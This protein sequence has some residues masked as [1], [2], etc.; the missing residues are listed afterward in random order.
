MQR[1]LLLAGAVCID[2]ESFAQA[3]SQM[4]KPR[5]KMGILSD[6]HIKTADDLPVLEKA[7]VFFRN[8]DVD[9]IVIAGDMADDGIARQL[10]M[11]G[12]TWYKVFPKDRAN[13]HKV[14]KIFV[15][16]NHDIEGTTY[17]S[18]KKRYSEE[19]GKQLIAD[20]S[21]A[22]HKDAAWKQAFKES[23]QPICLKEIKGFPF[24]ASQ[25]DNAHNT[26]G[27]AEFLQKNSRKLQGK[28]PFFYIQ[29]VHPKDTC[30]SPWVWGHDDGSATKILSQYPNCIC[31]SGHSHTT[32]TDERT[33]WQGAFTS[34]GTASLSY[35]ITFGGRENTSPAKYANIAPQMPKLSCQDGKQGQLMTVY[36]DFIT[37]ER[38]DFVYDQQ[39]A[40]NWIVPLPSPGQKPMDFSTR[41]EKA[42]AP[43]FAKDDKAVVTQAKGPDRNK[44]ETE[45]VTVHFPSVL[46]KKT[47]TRAFD[48]EVQAEM[49]DDD[50]Y[51]P[52]LTKRVFSNGY[53]LAEAQD[54]KEVTC[55]FAKAELPVGCKIR[56]A[57]RPA[58]CFG[59]KGEPI[60]TEWFKLK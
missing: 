60:F 24:V 29:H 23:W 5:L 40:D 57:V 41:A 32:L 9:G 58:E 56:F 33:I 1:S 26:P 51:Q 53:Y 38:H 3:V 49:L 30:S 34:V 8:H 42:K 35:L 10:K 20:E 37:L 11:V 50:V 18:F 6:V 28:K 39:L 44:K 4:G 55:V 36:D 16:G 12:N 46:G 14:A 31:F 27:L 52:V 15:T 21:I 54:E 48:Y 25:F 22:T 7:F 59:K 2:W 47:G 13:G 45:Q 43:Q 17:K 19:E